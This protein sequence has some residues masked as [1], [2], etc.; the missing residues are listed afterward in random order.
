MARVTDT[1]E[2]LLEAALQLIW[3]ESLGAASVDAICEKAEVRKG[4]FYHF[5][6]SKE[7][8]VA[9]ALETHFKAARIDF[10]RIFSPSVPPVDRLKG[11]FELMVRKQQMKLEKAGRVVGCPYASVAV[12]ISPEDTLVRDCVRDILSTWKKYFETALRDGAADGSIPVQDIPGTVQTI[13]DYIEGAMT[14]GRIQNSM[15]PIQNMGRIAFKLLSLEW[16]ASKMTAA[17]S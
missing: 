10:D 7:E 12:A 14:A 5:F 16:E 8:L 4:S 6:K 3:D 15:T 1:R 13:F 17:K 2:K 9:A 11:F